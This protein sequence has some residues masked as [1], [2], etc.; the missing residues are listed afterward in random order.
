MPD[1]TENFDLGDTS[2][3]LGN[4]GFD[5]GDSNLDL[6]PDPNPLDSVDLTGEIEA[7]SKAEVSAILSAFQDRS[8]RETEAKVEALDSEF[9]CCLCFQTR[10]Q[11][12]AF[13][14]AMKWDHLGDKYLDGQKVAQI[15]KVQIPQVKLRFVESQSKGS[16]KDLPKIRPL[17]TP[18]NALPPKKAWKEV[19]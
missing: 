7:D 19:K 2:L 14:Q 17:P 9:W 6:I 1:K 4:Q 8:R 13:L 16:M 3:D 5:L 15:Q 18:S 11:K 10:S 12:E